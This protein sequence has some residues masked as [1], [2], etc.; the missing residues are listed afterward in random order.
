MPIDLFFEELPD[1]E[2]NEHL[3]P[4]FKQSS[5]LRDEMNENFD[6][7]KI[8]A[9][10]ILYSGESNEKKAEHLFHLMCDDSEDCLDAGVEMVITTSKI[11]AIYAISVLLDLTCRLTTEIIDE[12]ST[13]C[14]VSDYC[15]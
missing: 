5:Y 2:K 8:C 3:S 6:F 13:Q 12:V 10:F 14:A 15:P 4:T 9:F 7:V 11:N 1:I